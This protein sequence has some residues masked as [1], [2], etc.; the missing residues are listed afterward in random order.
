MSALEKPAANA[1]PAVYGAIEAVMRDVGQKGI[2]KDQKNKQ[3][4]YKYRGIDDVYNA[5][6]P[7]LAQHHLVIVPRVINREKTERET[8]NGSVLFYVVVQVEFDI[9]CALDGSRHVA[10]TWGEA[11]DSGDKAT[12]K[13]M[14]AAYK[15]MAMQTFCIPTE[16]DNDADATSHDEIKPDAG[17]S[18]TQPRR[19]PPP[20][21][22]REAGAG[23]PP[24]APAQ[25]LSAKQARPDFD[26]MVKEIR[27]AKTVDDL[28]AWGKDNAKRVALQPDGWKRDLRKEY[29][30]R[31]EGLEY[32]ADTARDAE[33]VYEQEI[34]P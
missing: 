24:S 21:A 28:K 7:L 5:I 6:A 4:D 23:S 18:D 16:G 29:T 26:A 31:M 19:D 3:Q 33:R 11:M 2:A 1:L 9:I 10:S 20:K 32:M 13:A 15:Y 27:A 30:D 14:S 22:Q 34:Q 25:T 17:A 8:K 12:N